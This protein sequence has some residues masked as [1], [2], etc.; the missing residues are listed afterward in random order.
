MLTILAL[1]RR[2]AWDELGPVRA[3][4]ELVAQSRLAAVEAVPVHRVED[5]RIDAD[6][7]ELRVRIYV[8]HGGPGRRPATVYFHGG[9]FVLGDLESHDALCRHLAVRSGSTVIAVDYRLA[10]EHPFPAAVED[11][12]AAYAWALE[13]AGAL[14]IDPERIAVAGDSA[15]GNLAAVVAQD[16]RDRGLRPPAFQLLIYP[17]TDMSRSA[18]SHR[19]F[20]EGFLL[21]EAVI[22]WFFANYLTD[23]AQHRDPRCS[24]LLARDLSGLPPAHVVTA[25]FDPLRDEGEQY[26]EAL[27]AAGVEATS[28]CYDTLIHGFVSM[29]GLIEAAA[30]AV[31]DLGDV[32]R[33]RLW[34]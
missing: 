11:A 1:A 14:G 7:D 4:R 33:A 30:R 28:R 15:G 2:P 27:R 8:P 32:L 34:P 18:A 23:P 24:P 19:T 22:D 6:H 25:G 10:P 17:A 20:A 31:D 5:R 13:S 12:C 26:A 3:R 16:A 29:S 9:G 21:T